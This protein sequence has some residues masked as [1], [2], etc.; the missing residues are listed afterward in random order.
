MKNP[1]QANPAQQLITQDETPNLPVL[2]PKSNV[3]RPTKYRPEYCQQLLAHFSQPL[4]KTVIKK[5]TTKAGTV[6][7][8]PIEKPNELPTIE[9][10]AESIGV[11]KD[12]I[13]DWTNKYPE[14]LFA[15]RR[16]KQIFRDF[17]VRNG[18]T[19]RYDSRFAQF[20]AINDTDMRD[21]KE[22][23]TLNFN[24]TEVDIS[25]AELDAD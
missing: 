20:V 10:F 12:V 25:E 6:I 23:V 17:I 15:Y 19:G 3:G 1:V 11:V 7:E 16:A 8:E 22:V 2:V 5:Y 24:F 18:I 14:F 4:T 13:I 21:R 9:G